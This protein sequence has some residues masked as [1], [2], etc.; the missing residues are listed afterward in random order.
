MHAHGPCIYHPARNANRV[1]SLKP[2]QEQGVRLPILPRSQTSSQVWFGARRPCARHLSRHLAPPPRL[3]W[4]W[5]HA[6][7]PLSQSTPRRRTSLQTASRQPASKALSQSRTRRGG[8]AAA[9]PPAHVT[10]ASFSGRRPR[11]R[12]RYGPLQGRY[13]WAIWA[14][15]SSSWASQRSRPPMPLGRIRNSFPAF[16]CSDRSLQH[17]ATAV[18]SATG[19]W[20]ALD[21]RWTRAGHALDTRWTRAGHA[22]DTRWTAACCAARRTRSWCGHPAG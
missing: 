14:I 15:A 16:L 11:R 6:S 1:P 13:F 10:A 5:P 8:G 4:P 22:L 9:G 17:C 20:H 21:T 3:C 2:C 12:E 18:S 19:T 7:P